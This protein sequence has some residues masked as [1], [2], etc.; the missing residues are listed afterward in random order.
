MKEFKFNSVFNLFISD[1][2]KS[3]KSAQSAVALKN[4][5]RTQLQLARIRGCVVWQEHSTFIALV[6]AGSL[7]PFACAAIQN[8]PNFGRLRYAAV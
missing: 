3:V 4:A 8:E 1:K 2:S 7:R 6:P 5:K